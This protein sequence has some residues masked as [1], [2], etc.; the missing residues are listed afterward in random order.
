MDNWSLY[1]WKKKPIQKQQ[2]DYPKESLNDL[3]QIYTKLK[4]LPP[5]VNEIEIEK[6][7]SQ[8][9]DCAL[10]NRF[11]LQGG[12]CAE[13][14][15]YCNDIEISNK[16]KILLQM[17]LILI[18][19]L[20]I[21]VV[22]V[23]R[24]AGQ[25]GKPRSKPT[26]IVNGKE[27]PSYRGDNINSIDLNDRTPDPN[28]LLLAYFHSATTL[29]YVRSSLSNGLADLRNPEHW[30]IHNFEL[31]NQIHN[32]ENKSKL[33][34]TNILNQLKNALDFMKVIGIDDNGNNNED[35]EDKYYNI[36]EESD[37]KEPNSKKPKLINTINNNNKNNS[38]ISSLEQKIN[39][40]STA[41][42]FMS[43]E[44]LL[45][46]YES[47]LTR[48][49][50]TN[51]NKYYNYGTHFIWIGART[52][53]IDGSHIEYFRGI[54]NPIGIKVGPDTSPEELIRILDI[55]DPNCEI[56]KVTLITRFGS[57]KCEQLLGSYIDKVNNHT[58]IKRDEQDDSKIVFK[59]KHKV[60]WCCDPMHGN[61]ETI[62]EDKIKTRKFSNVMKELEISIK[63][64][65]QKNNLLN[66]IHLELTGDAVTEVIGGT[67]RLTS[68]DLK[69]NYKT[70]CDPRLN[71]FQALDIAFLLSNQFSK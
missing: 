4:H 58:V 57:E 37:I 68:N 26:E 5:L 48:Q 14:F 70:F 56:G 1:S 54:E 33:Q 38:Q 61:T 49:S 34:Y 31:L 2:V 16:I 20:R 11:L 55:V 62:G 36:T 8:L 10:G 42:I 47:T 12:D 50:T 39:S 7:K 51:P 35:N 64:H 18:W 27:Y 52:A 67:Q 53:Q 60:V 19:G 6:L 30:N 28:K 23:A 63:I 69:D 41:E 59:R 43:H 45:L 46:D 25:Y 29:N 22:R 24:M 13:I 3:N 44:G 9:R 15:D 32:D 66:G 40:L 65:K 21:P 71:C 17:S